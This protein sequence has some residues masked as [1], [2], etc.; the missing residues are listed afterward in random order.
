MVARLNNGAA[1]QREGAD[2]KLGT[3]I[4]W[5]ADAVAVHGLAPGPWPSGPGP[6]VGNCGQQAVPEDLPHSRPLF[7]GPE[8]GRLFRSA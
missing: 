5:A 4:R 3:R 6:R 2:S 7:A 1:K 8:H